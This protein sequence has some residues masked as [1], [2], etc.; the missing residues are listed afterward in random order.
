[1]E[2]PVVHDPVFARVAA[3]YAFA[4]YSIEATV[5]NGL[6][7]RIRSEAP[8]GDIATEEVALIDVAVFRGSCNSLA[9]VGHTRGLIHIGNLDRR[10]LRMILV[11]PYTYVF[12]SR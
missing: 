12:L 5:P 10:Q 8:F 4:A 3:Q 2:E 7:L 9:L 6:T 1:M 11:E